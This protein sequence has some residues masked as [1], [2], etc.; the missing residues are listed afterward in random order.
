MSAAK[1]AP[2]CPGCSSTRSK[3]HP[4]PRFA[5]KV[6]I[7]ECGAVY[8]TRPIYKGDAALLISPFMTAEAVPADRTFYY[9]IDVLGS[10][11]LHRRHG[12]AAMDLKGASG[13]A[14]VVQVG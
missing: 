10:D 2:E 14:L 9:D 1:F 6:R 8:S 3:A 12:W 13:G 5:D 4:D 11:G 7:C